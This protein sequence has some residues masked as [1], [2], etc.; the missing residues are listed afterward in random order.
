MK[1]MLEENRKRTNEM[2]QFKNN[3]GKHGYRSEGNEKRE[4]CV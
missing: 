3:D 2:T 4:L 1:K